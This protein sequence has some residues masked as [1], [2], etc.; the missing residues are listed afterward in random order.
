MN[1][2][3][4]IFASK[5]EPIKSYSD[6]WN[7]FA[8]NEKAFY[9]VVKESGNI[10]EVFFDK[11]STQLN[12][13]KDGFFFVTGMFDDNTVELIITAE[14]SIEDIVFVEKL[15]NAA[16]KING[17]KFTPLKPALDI[18]NVCIEMDGYRYDSENI[19]F[20]SNEHPDKPDEIDITVVYD[21]FNEEDKTS[22]TNGVFIFLDNFLGELNFA[23]TIDSVNV[24]GKNYTQKELIKIEKLKDF[25]TW[26]EKEFVEKYEGVRHNTEKDNYSALE[27]T[28]ENGKPL[29]AIINSDLLAWDSKASHPW[30]LNI[31]IKYNGE[32]KNGMPDNNTYKLMDKIEDDIL[33]TLKDYDGYLNVGRQTA[34]GVR[35]IYFACKDFRKPS[36][37]LHDIKTKYAGKIDIGYDIY[38]DKYWS[39]FERF[40][41]N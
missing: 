15:I 18:T 23:T 7:W 10:D 34:D 29:V 39:S 35:E 22:I 20:Y 37:V 26:R 25:L 30:I 16:P 36:L 2:L 24:I 40:M 6:F 17:W 4:N 1:F 5:E 3:K 41:R 38:K 8:K 27:A 14:G 12:K 32:N 21:N 31:E 19:S 13:I 33:L 9:I 28:L 11:L